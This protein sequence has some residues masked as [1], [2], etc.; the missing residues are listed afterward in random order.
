[1][2]ARRPKR[3]PPRRGGLCYTVRESVCETHLHGR[4]EPHHMTIRVLMRKWYPNNEDAVIELNLK[5]NFQKE[6]SSLRSW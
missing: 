2:P 3:C 5:T 6:T 4:L 1:M